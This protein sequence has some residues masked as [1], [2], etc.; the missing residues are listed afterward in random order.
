[1]GK[2][3][4]REEEGGVRRTKEKEGK[5]R[6]IGGHLVGCS[7]VLDEEGEG[8]GHGG[9]WC[10]VRERGG[11]REGREGEVGGQGRGGRGKRGENEGRTKEDEGR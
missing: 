4:G 6:K 9:A 3:E 1:L 7:E 5:G 2:G 10:W 11:R 8:V